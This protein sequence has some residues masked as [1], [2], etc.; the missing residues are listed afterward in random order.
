MKLGYKLEYITSDKIKSD[1]R[2]SHYFNIY[3][4]VY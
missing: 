3:I 2:I 4:Y 1:R